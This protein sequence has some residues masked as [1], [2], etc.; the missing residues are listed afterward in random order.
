MEK[1]SNNLDYPKIVK[2]CTLRQSI[3]LRSDGST[4]LPQMSVDDYRKF[5]VWQVLTPYLTNIRKYDDNDASN[6][7]KNW[8]DRCSQLKRLQFNLNHVVKYDINSAKRNGYLLPINRKQLKKEVK[9]RKHILV[10]RVV[11]IL[12]K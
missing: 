8:L 10:Q 7:I 1:S 5:V 6:M 11:Q 2:R 9:E 12:G 3:Q 4:R